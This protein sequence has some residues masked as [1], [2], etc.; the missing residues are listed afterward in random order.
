MSQAPRQSRGL[1][2]CAA[3]VPAFGLAAAICGVCVPILAAKAGACRRPG[4]ASGQATARTAPC[5]WSDIQQPVAH[6]PDHDLLL[7]AKTQ[8]HLNVVDGVPD[9]DHLDSPCLR[10]CDV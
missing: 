3:C 6:G 7:R 1:Q 9:G 10:N 8:L 2:S 4:T 5:G